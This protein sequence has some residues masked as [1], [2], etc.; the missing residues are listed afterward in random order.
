MIT[1]N[2]LRLAQWDDQ[3]FATACRHGLVHLTWGRITTRLT[4]N[5]FRQLA[6]LLQQA[7]DASPPISLHDRD[8]RI[9]TRLDEDCEL[10][11][12]PLVLLLSPTHFDALVRLA[13]EAVDRLDKILASGVWD[14]D[15]P[16]QG[17]SDFLEQFRR[18][19]F[20]RN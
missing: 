11:I 16:E 5:E 10:Q 18:I 8:L 9:T 13:Q 2:F 19:H 1:P 12:G 20:S 4:R 15:E 3:H 7:E 6:A 14:R 17:P